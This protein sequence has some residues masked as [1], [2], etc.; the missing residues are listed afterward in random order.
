MDPLKPK[1][2]CTNAP[3]LKEDS[4]FNQPSYLIVHATGETPLSKRSPFLIQKLFESSIGHLKKIQKM[5]SGDLLVEAASPQQSEKLM[6]MKSLGDIQVTTTPHTSLNSSRGVIS[7]IDLM[8]ENE[9]DIQIG[10]SDQGVT[11]VRRISIRR[12]GKLIPTKHLI[13]T[14]GKPSLPSFI[15]AGY[16]RCPVRPYIPNPLRCFKCQRFGHSQTSCRG[17]S[18][19]AQCGIEGHQSTECTSTPRCVNCSDA[20]PAYSR[21]CS[22]WQREKEIQRVKTVNNI[23]YPEARRMVNPSASLKQKSF[24]AALKSTKTIGVQTDISVCPKESL[25]RHAKCLLLPSEETTKENTK[26]KTPLPK[27]GVITRNVGSKKASKNPLNKQRVKVA[28]SKSKKS[29]AQSMSEFSDISDEENNMEVTK[30]TSPPKGKSSVKLKRD[31]FSKNTA[32]NT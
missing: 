20:H 7:E 23:S 17:K 13:L 30:P 27:T 19:C 25:T 28:L 31:T 16:L 18:L 1:K 6:K 2:L 11:A 21:K 3:P 26:T 15:T 9:S 10:L 5:R 8:S 24:A 4:S 22:A 12:D 29:E 14:F 32:S